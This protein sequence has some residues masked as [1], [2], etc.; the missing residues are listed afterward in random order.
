MAILAWF[1]Q[2]FRMRFLRVGLKHN[3]DSTVYCESFKR[4]L[5][6]AKSERFSLSHPFQ[7]VSCC[8]ILT[9][10]VLDEG[11]PATEFSFVHAKKLRLQQ[12]RLG[13]PD[14]FMQMLR[15]H[16]HT[17]VVYFRVRIIS[18]LLRPWMGIDGFM[19][20]F[21]LGSYNSSVMRLCLWSLSGQKRGH[22]MYRFQSDPSSL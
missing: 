13:Q 7:L 21:W 2:D 5:L 3:W 1:F 12:S 8:F 15:Q 16:G 9:G 19:K 14:D 22:S 10:T 18:I 4:F 17:R 11:K 20:I 6:E